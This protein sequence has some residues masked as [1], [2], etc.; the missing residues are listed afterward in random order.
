MWQKNEIWKNSVE[1]CALRATCHQECR[2]QVLLSC[3]PVG[4]TPTKKGAPKTIAD[5]APTKAPMVSALIVHCVREVEACSLTEVG[6][7]RVLDAERDYWANF[8]NV[9]TGL[10]SNTPSEPFLTPSTE[11]LLPG[12]S[13]TKYLHTPGPREERLRLV[14]GRFSKIGFHD[15]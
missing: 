7:Y 2:E 5:F 13:S 12:G 6:I 3:V 10:M 11:C 15:L 8:V 4:I 14:G 1:A 9:D